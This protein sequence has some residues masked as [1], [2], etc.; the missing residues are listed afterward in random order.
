M[1]LS[2]RVRFP[3]VAQT[4]SAG[5]SEKDAKASFVRNRKPEPCPPRADR[6]GGAEDT[7]ER[8]ELVIRGRFPAVAP[9]GIVR[10]MEKAKSFVDEFKAF[11]LRGN[12]LDLAIGVVIGAAF[13]AITNS[14]VNDVI[15]P[16][17]GL[18]IGGI[19]FSELAIPL[20]PEVSITYGL[21]IQALINFIIIAFALFLIVKFL[22]KMVKKEEAKP[23]AKSAELAVL[24]E[25]RDSLK[26]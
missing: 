12:A 11:A 22:N 2:I 18:L 1:V 20:G 25:I 4:R 7:Y 19:D 13:G 16:P 8:S 23:S 17:L 26:K 14:L 9:L 21:F 24:E 6:R 10:H 15:T 3:A 5:E